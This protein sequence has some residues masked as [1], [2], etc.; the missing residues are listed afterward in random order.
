MTKEKELLD[1]IKDEIKTLACDLFKKYQKE[2]FKD[3]KNYVKKME[4]DIKRWG[5]LLA[6]GELSKKDFKIMKV[7]IINGPNINMLGI[8]EPDIYGKDTLETINTKIL[9]EMSENVQLE[10]FQSNSE[11]EVIERIQKIAVDKT[12]D[13]LVINP[14]AL[15]HYSIAIKDALKIIGV[16]KIEVHLS[17][18]FSREAFRHTSVTASECDA[19]ISGCGW[20]GYVL[21]IKQIE[22]KK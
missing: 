20:Y 17:N 12:A 22:R 21:A 10:F 16:P 9:S 18:I 5:K 14:A 8:R 6:L 2:A 4:K 7:L 11:A 1:D 19:V 13:A 3:G 15:T